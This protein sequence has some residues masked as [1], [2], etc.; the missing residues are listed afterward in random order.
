MPKVLIPALSALLTFFIYSFVCRSLQVFPFSKEGPNT[1]VW[2]DAFYQYL[3]FFGWMKDILAGKQ[4]LWYTFSSSLGQN[5]AGIF[6]YYLAS[7]FNLLLFFF[8]RTKIQVFFNI[9]IGLKMSACSCT[10]AVYLQ[11]R[12]RKLQPCFVLILSLCCGLMQY[13]FSQSSNLMWIDGVYMLPLILL[14]V[15]RLVDRRHQLSCGSHVFPGRAL[16]ERLQ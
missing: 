4:S 3:D 13:N 1:L 14:G 8:P 16:Y 10:M 11:E 12:V 6:S 9:V 2:A 7:P 5:S 15:Y